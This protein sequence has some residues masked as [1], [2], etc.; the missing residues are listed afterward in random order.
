MAETLCQALGDLADARGDDLALV[1]SDHSFTW[2]ELDDAVHRAAAGL[3]DLGVE[4]G[5]LVGLVLPRTPALAVVFLAIARVGALAVPI[6]HKLR[7]KWITAQL[8]GLTGLVVDTAL[9]SALPDEAQVTG[10]RTTPDRLLESEPVGPKRTFSAMPETVCYLNCT[11]GSTGRPKRAV[12]TNAQI[13]ANARATVQSSGQEADDVFWCLFAPFA[14]PHE[15]FHRSLISGAA[16][17]MIDTMSPR[18]VSRAVATNGVSH[19]LALPGFVELW[20]DSGLLAE[21][22]NSPRIIE[23]GGSIVT[24]DLHLRMGEAFSG[25]FFAVWGS[26]ET[27]GVAIVSRGQGGDLLSGYALK[28]ID[29]AGRALTTGEVGELC[30]SGPAVVSGYSPASADPV[31][32][33][34]NGWFHTGDLVSVDSLGKVHFLGRRSTLLKVGGARVFPAEVERVLCAHPLVSEAV[35]V[36]IPDRRRGEI[37]VALV[38]ASSELKDDPGRLS[39]HCRERLAVYKV[40]RQTVFVDALPRL[41]GGKVDRPAV[42][43]LFS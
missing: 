21:T 8:D 20:L 36:G 31:A 23:A 27:T 28:V 35:V 39:V 34:N 15:F 19:V 13:M 6:N 10:W 29:E 18:V 12:T 43:A 16:F 25:Q 22:A 30:L 32:P 1:G 9:A 24:P 40:P 11:S 3:V 4:P 17:V 26:T 38:V 14:H 33:F 42:V 7:T 5:Q 41:P 2:S 37:P